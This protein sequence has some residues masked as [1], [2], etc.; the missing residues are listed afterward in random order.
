MT[1]ARAATLQETLR[2]K[3]LPTNGLGW[4]HEL[5]RGLPYRSLLSVAKALKLSEKDMLKAMDISPRVAAARKKAKR[6]NCAESDLLYA[7]ARAY[8]RL[9][10]F[11]PL[12][13]ATQ[14]LVSKT[15]V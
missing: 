7:I 15:E 4:H 10:S 8:V 6:L 9:A 12:Q 13:E 3:K 11:K 2:L 1:T 5:R 14:W